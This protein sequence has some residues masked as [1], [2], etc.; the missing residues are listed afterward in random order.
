MASNERELIQR[1]QQA[2]AQGDL[3]DHQL[4][5][6]LEALFARHHRSVSRYCQRKTR[7]AQRAAD[8]SQDVML[9]ACRKLPEFRGDASFGTWLIGIARLVCLQDRR[10]RED[11]LTADGVIEALD[12]R[13][14]ALATLRREERL[15]VIR[16]A[17]RTL[18]PQEQ[19]AIELRYVHEVPRDTITELLGLTNAS[20]ARGLLVRCRR[21]LKRAI[22]EVLEA[23]G[24]GM[25]LLEATVTVG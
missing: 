8:L 15:E 24:H 22:V 6:Q 10:R 17:A 4:Q 18:T 21:K 12:P 2:M 25:S 14:S 7:S 13:H 23:R 3:L 19:E 9:V 1:I 20:G 16:Q 11:L 5:Q